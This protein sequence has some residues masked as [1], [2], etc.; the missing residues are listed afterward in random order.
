MRRITCRPYYRM[1]LSAVKLKI[2]RL[3]DIVD[4]L[5]NMQSRTLHSTQY[6]ALS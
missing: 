5:Y 1:W 4:K 3:N 2:N 6:R